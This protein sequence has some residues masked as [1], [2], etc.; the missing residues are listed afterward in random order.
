MSLK[1]RLGELGERERKLLFVFF[2]ILFVLITVLVPV[3]VRMGVSDR[4]SENQA[5]SE[6]IEQISD[7]RLTIAKR[8]QVVAR[9]ESRYRRTAPALAGFLA[10]V[11]DRVDAE[12]PETQDRSVV[13]HGKT[14]K[15]RQTRI[16]LTK[17]GMRALSDF[18]EGVVSAGYPVVIS[19]LEIKKGTNPD[20]FDA[21]MDVSAFDREDTKPKAKPAKKAD[22]PATKGAKDAKDEDE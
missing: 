8:K 5:I 11:A 7:E 10:N 21:E 18:M 12:I 17:I 20:Q 15:E 3:W 2:G 14:F 4:A 1:E 19:R 22:S 6:M 9:V 16:R 13:P